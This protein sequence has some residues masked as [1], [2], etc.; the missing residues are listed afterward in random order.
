MI[1]CHVPDHSLPCCDRSNITETTPRDEKFSVNSNYQ[2]G[3]SFSKIRTVDMKMDT[4]SCSRVDACSHI[5]GPVFVRDGS[6][7]GIL[8]SMSE[9]LCS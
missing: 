8:C 5:S 3:D 2:I 1:A 9:A 7:P 6:K 4:Y